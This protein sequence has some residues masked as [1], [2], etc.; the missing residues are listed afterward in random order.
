MELFDNL[1]KMNTIEMGID[2]KKRNIGLDAVDIV[3][4]CVNKMKQ[5]KI[6]I[7]RKGKS[8]MWLLME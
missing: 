1:D 6:Y 4:Y 2:I 3:E 5:S 8:I 7:E